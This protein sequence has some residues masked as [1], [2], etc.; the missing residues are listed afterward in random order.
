VD[1]P[2]KVTH[3]WTDSKQ[4][5]ILW[6]KMQAHGLAITITY[7]LVDQDQHVWDLEYQFWWHSVWYGGQVMGR[8]QKWPKA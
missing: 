7:D 8:V 5:E 4:Q 2:Q 1:L 6:L 3:S